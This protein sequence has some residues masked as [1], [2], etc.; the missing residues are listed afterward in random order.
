L[1][2]ESPLAAPEDAASEYLHSEYLHSPAYRPTH[3][4]TRSRCEMCRFPVH[5]AVRGATLDPS[6]RGGV[7]SW[8]KG[9]PQGLTGGMVWAAL[10]DHLGARPG[11][12]GCFVVLEP[13]DATPPDLGTRAGR[14]LRPYGQ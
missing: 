5:D 4:L 8:W 6:D 10:P 14:R 2:V 1:D 9:G 13:G 12:P 3:P 11:A 7:A